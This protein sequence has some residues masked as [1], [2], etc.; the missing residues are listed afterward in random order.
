MAKVDRL[1]TLFSQFR[2]PDAAKEKVWIETAVKINGYVEKVGTIASIKEEF[3]QGETSPI[4]IDF[5]RPYQKRTMGVLLYVKLAIDDYLESEQDNDEK[6]LLNK[7]SQILGELYQNP[8]ENTK[9]MPLFELVNEWL[10][11][12]AATTSNKDKAHLLT[13]CIYT[14]LSCLKIK[15]DNLTYFQSMAAG[16]LITSAREALPQ[17]ITSTE[18]KGKELESQLANIKQENAGKEKNLEDHYNER[19]LAILNKD[20]E[21]QR[22]KLD[23][24]KRTAEQTTEDIKHLLE[25]RKEKT[26][27]EENISKLEEF[28]KSIKENQSLDAKSKSFTELLTCNPD[29]YVFLFSAY[30]EQI[31]E[32]EELRAKINEEP[33]FKRGLKN[34]GS[35][36]LSYI[37]PFT[38]KVVKDLLSS[39]TPDTNDSLAKRKLVEQIEA[40]LKHL[41]A[42]VE[43]KDGEISS[44]ESKLGG[45][46]EQLK[47]VIKVSEPDALQKI[48]L[49]NNIAVNMVDEFNNVLG[50]IEAIGKILKDMDE[51]S[52]FI[53]KNDLWHK[54]A[55]DTI[56][57]FFSS[58]FSKVTTPSL[59]DKIEKCRSLKDSLILL[60]REYMET[61]ESTFADFGK[62]HKNPQIKESLKG[63][64]EEHVNKISNTKVGENFNDL[65]Q[66]FTLI[67]QLEPQNP[68]HEDSEVVEVQNPSRTL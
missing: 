36:A 23:I 67:R 2:G 51:A 24:L 17:L 64:F 19:Y 35:I 46:N 5:E 16:S 52:N 43:L 44:L 9:V 65:K 30:P 27:L 34:A 13:K 11:N 68:T 10:T 63:H 1:R 29:K 53:Q 54:K 42:R 26:N 59:A 48:I 6:R 3:S 25:I 21:G 60:S 28:L 49:V 31:N 18:A 20:G 41:K 39:I 33:D 32:L 45:D 57:R 61:L 66:K 8:I 55:F 56:S 40:A 47:Q 62:D 12:H 15:M 37:A 4:Y 38:P 50:P 22:T 7:I 14:M 58:I